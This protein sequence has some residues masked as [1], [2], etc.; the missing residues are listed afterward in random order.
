M[1]H[2][3]RTFQ[4]N[5]MVQ[6]HD[7]TPAQRAQVVCQMITHAGDYGLVTHLS[8]DLGV[9]RQTLYSWMERGW[10]AVE[11]AFL[12]VPAPLT[13]TPALHRQV[14]T[15]LVEGHAT[16]RGIQA[17]LRATTTQHVSL[18]T[19]SAII[20]E[21]QQR[22]LTWMATHA[23]PTSRAIALDEIYGRRRCGAYL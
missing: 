15:L 7:S 8:R 3:H 13:I 11:A 16:V 4:G 1:C 12:P 14:L 17:C 20:Q 22:S 19:I 5:T 6:R 9:S 21:A 2:H 23:P 18:G 10:Q